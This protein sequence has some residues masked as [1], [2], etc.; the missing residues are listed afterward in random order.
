MT[1]EER[2]DIINYLANMYDDNFAMDKGEIY[3]Y[4]DNLVKGKRLTRIEADRMF[5]L[6]VG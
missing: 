6:I 5:D 1:L 2:Q 3:E 4:L